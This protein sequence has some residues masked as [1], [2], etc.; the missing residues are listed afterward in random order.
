MRFLAT[1]LAVFMFVC[2]SAQRMSD[3]E[4]FFNQG[5]YREAGSI[6]VQALKK[7]PKDGTLNFK[8]ARCLYEQGQVT[9]ATLY[10]E[11][12]ALF[13]FAKSNRFLGD[14][15]FAD[16]RFQE[17]AQAY[18]A[19][20]A[21]DKLPADEKMQV[22]KL[23]AKAK[24]GAAMLER[25]EDIGVIDSVKADKRTFI[26][27]IKM[28]REMGFFAF[29]ADL[30]GLKT[31]NTLT[32]FQSGRNDRRYLALQQGDRQSDLFQSFNVLKEW[33]EPVV[34]SS[35]L[36]TPQNENYP[37]VAADGITI[38]FG[39]EGHEGLGG[40]DIFMSRFNSETAD[41]LPPQNVG[42]PFNST[43]NDYMMA[44]DELAGLGWFVTDRYQHPDS[45]I[46]YR[47]VPN[48]ERLILRN[49]TLQ[50]LRDAAR[51][52][53][54]RTVTLTDEKIE[55]Q[56]VIAQKLQA[57]LFWVNDTI[58]Y[59]SAEQFVSNEAR[60]QFVALC[61]LKAQGEQKQFTLEAKRELWDIIEDENERQVFGN[62][63]VTLEKSCLLIQ[64]QLMRYELD[65]RTLE[66]VQLLTTD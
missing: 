34:L 11:Q 62:E 65:I 58:V 41:Y 3:A 28:A 51:M 60:E 47:F 50:E 24:L 30:L 18:D 25:V 29:S 39:S 12:A 31:D 55:I 61:E 44:F 64:Q 32:A 36:N 56:E 49:K 35:I 4:A 7:T 16:Y 33:S 2:V 54:Y 37:F 8:Y 40:Y 43:Y 63:I 42:M 38:Y 6:Y 59:H 19:W 9:E 48:T 45:V 17:A 27:Q 26:R 15:Y 52:R 13:G 20:L 10:F 66:N 21:S 46:I 22:T 57:T 23:A 53:S 5:H 14:I 1:F